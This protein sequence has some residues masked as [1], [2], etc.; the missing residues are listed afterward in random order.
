MAKMNERLST[1]L[2]K[3]ELDP[4]KAVWDCHG[5][6]VAYH[7]ACE[8]IAREA[9]V[10]FESP[11]LMACDL[12]TNTVAV[13]VTGRIGDIAEW[14]FGEAAPNNNKNSYPWAMAE[15]RAKDRVILK[16]VG[17]H[18]EVYSEEEADDFKK[19]NQ[20]GYLPT[21][22]SFNKDADLDFPSQE[23]DVAQFAGWEEW[24]KTMRQLVSEA[25]DLGRLKALWDDNKVHLEAYDKKFHAMHDALKAQFSV[26][27]GML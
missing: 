3:Y 23:L 8:Q 12:S 16:L 5:T 25:P 22:K 7:W 10:V 17:L 6:W 24:D 21:M 9:G 19:S 13:C 1:I 14:S 11:V 4:K 2:A 18:G 26:R 27:K 20:P 15:K